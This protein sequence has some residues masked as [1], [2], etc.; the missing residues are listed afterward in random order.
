MCAQLCSAG[1]RCCAGGSD[2]AAGSDVGQHVG[3]FGLADSGASVTATKPSCTIAQ[4][5]WA[6]PM[7][8]CRSAGSSRYRVG[9]AVAGSFIAAAPAHLTDA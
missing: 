6:L 8:A 5:R 7:T 4:P 1:S 2:V 9:I 3:A